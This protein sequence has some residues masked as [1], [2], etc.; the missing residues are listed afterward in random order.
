V[1]QILVQ[2]VVFAFLISYKVEFYQWAKNYKKTKKITDFDYDFS[3]E[4]KD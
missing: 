3:D 4:K 2:T 1:L